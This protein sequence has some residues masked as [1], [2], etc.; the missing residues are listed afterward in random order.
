M[1][2]ALGGVSSVDAA[3]ALAALD[4]LGYALVPV[5]PSTGLLVSM[6]MR[7][8]HSFG[9]PAYDFGGIQMG[10]TPEM[11]ASLLVSMGQLH[12]EVVGTGFYRA[13]REARYTGIVEKGGNP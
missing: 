11:R 4:A 9:L 13:D 6:A 2:A 1:A 12:E 5:Q 3:R 10:Y 8:D 7:W